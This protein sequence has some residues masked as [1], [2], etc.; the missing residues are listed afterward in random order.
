M[1]FA[2]YCIRRVERELG[3][4]EAWLVEIAPSSGT[5]ATRI[6]VHDMC[7]ALEANGSGIDG[8]LATWEAICRIEESLRECYRRPTKPAR[9]E[10]DV[11]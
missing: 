4:R 5:Y 6:E 11:L 9:G 8:A 1:A 7:G 10:D 3:E 2:R